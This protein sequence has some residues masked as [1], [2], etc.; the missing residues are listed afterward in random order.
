MQAVLNKRK[1]AAQK[2]ICRPIQVCP[3][4]AILYIEDENEPLGGKIVIEAALCNGCGLCVPECCGSA[5]DMK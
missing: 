1:C 4:Q 3:T 2:D 5:I